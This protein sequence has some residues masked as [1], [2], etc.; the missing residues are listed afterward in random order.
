M[1]TNGIQEYIYTM[2]NQLKMLHKNQSKTMLP[3]MIGQGKC[4]WSQF[5]GS[6]RFIQEMWKS[7]IEI[8]LVKRLHC[9]IYES[10]LEL[11]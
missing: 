8:V 1:K 9:L 10:K 5:P 2:D 4:N 11:H 3:Q 6:R 7:D